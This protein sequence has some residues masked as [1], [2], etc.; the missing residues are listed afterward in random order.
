[1]KDFY[2]L[3][4]K[5]LLEKAPVGV[6]IHRWNTCI[7]YANPT[8][9]R[10]FGLTI[11]QIIGKDTFDPKWSFVDDAGKQLQLEDYP[12]NKIKRTQEP[13][14]NEIIGVVSSTQEQPR[15]LMVNAYMEGD[16]N[17]D[18]R[19]IIVSFN[20]ISDFKQLY[21]FSDI[22]EN[23][24]DIVIVCEADNIKYP[25]GPKIIYV[26][27]AFETLTGY[28]KDEVIGETPR[29]LQGDLTD[30]E[31]MSRIKIALTNNQAVTETLLNYDINGRPYW[32]EMN[33]IPLKNKYGE[34]THF[35][36]IERDVS[37]RK[38]HLEQLQFRNQ[39]L[40]ALK[41]ELEQLVQ[42]RT[43]E[44]QKAKEKLEKIAFLDPLT[45]IPN[46]RFFIDQTHRLIKSCNRRQLSIAFGLLDIDDFKLVNDTHGHDAGDLILKELANYL[47][48]FFRADEAYC[49][50]GGEEFA[51]TVVI[52]RAADLEIITARLINGIR[53]LKVSV[54]GHDL[55]VTASAGFKLCHPSYGVDF[56]KEMKQA[57]VAL[58]QS[59]KNGKN[60]ATILK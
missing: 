32:I 47:R 55:S 6:I 38:F 35:G 58:Y 34:V 60:R 51:F 7:V 4:L 45:N 44:L 52:E 3:N 59:K 23:T 25:T 33:I 17:S 39:E 40:K 26:N 42:E 10:L 31:A 50:Y 16:L 11:D 56:E 18:N 21:F 27:K 41:S 28:K 12:V 57:D 2:G 9:L 43:V 36:A 8:A 19:S 14:Q 1:M 5:N 53:D 13:I 20:D 30:K 22:V 46:R 24:Q 48:V 15:W 49:R 37:E 54:N 29:I